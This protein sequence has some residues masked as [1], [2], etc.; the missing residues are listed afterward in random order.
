[1]NIMLVVP[2]TQAKQVY[3]E[4]LKSYQIVKIDQE[5]KMNLNL[6]NANHQYSIQDQI[7]IK[8][9]IHLKL[10]LLIEVVELQASKDM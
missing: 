5:G 4:I 3:L 9:Y 6:C 2:M 1:M 7:D 8:E 10:P